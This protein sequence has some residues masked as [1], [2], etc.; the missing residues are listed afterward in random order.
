MALTDLQ[1]QSDGWRG[2][3]TW[4]LGT[5]KEDSLFVDPTTVLPVDP[6]ILRP[7]RA[8]DHASSVASG[9]KEAFLQTKSYTGARQL[10]QLKVQPLWL[11][12]S[13]EPRDTFE[14]HQFSSIFNFTAGEMGEWAEI[15]DPRSKT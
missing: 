9:A 12:L 3:Q 4:G 2:R 6:T 8:L 10:K 13:W 15:L 11:K 14:N 1:V 7:G 5:G